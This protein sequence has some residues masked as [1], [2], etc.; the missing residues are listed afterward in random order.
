VL[1]A[2]QVLLGE[3]AFALSRIRARTLRDHE[4]PALAG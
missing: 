3:G 4:A 1:A 2:A